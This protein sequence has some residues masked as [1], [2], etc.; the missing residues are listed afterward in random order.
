MTE[1]NDEGLLHNI[2][3]PLPPLKCGGKKKHQGKV[4]RRISV[5]FEI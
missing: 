4:N 1:K 5:L 2:P 3:H